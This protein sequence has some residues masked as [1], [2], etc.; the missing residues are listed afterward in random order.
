MKLGYARVSTG[1]QNLRM[2]IDALKSAGVE[3]IFEDKGVSGAAVLKPAY[4]EM[5][6]MAR[7]GDE[8]V[9]WRM[10]RMSRSLLALITELQML[11]RLDLSF[12]SLSEQID[13]ATPAGQLFFH[14]VGAFAQFE[15]DVTRERTRAGLDAARRDGVKLGRPSALSASQWKQVVELLGPPSNMSV[16]SV[17]NLLGVSRQTIYNRIKAEPLAR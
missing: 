4:G 14:M 3:R 11:K 5:L 15:L 1:E 12:R 8:I 16:A 7:P 6:K 17:A 13:T 10:D 9:V 2:Q